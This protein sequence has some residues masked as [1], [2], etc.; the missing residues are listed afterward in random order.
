MLY[1]FYASLRRHV[2]RLRL[3]LLACALIF[4]LGIHQPR[5]AHAQN[6]P[7]RMPTVSAENLNE[8][9][10]V[11]PAQLP[12][13]KTLV[14]MAF[15]REQQTALNTWIDGMGLKDDKLPWIETP[16]I[17]KPF[18]LVRGFIDRGMRRGIPDPAM[19]ERTITLYT[20]PEE[21]RRVMGLSGDGKQVWVLVVDRS[22]LVLAQAT[23][24]YS[25]DKAKPLLDALSSSPSQTH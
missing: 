18:G 24:N 11:L 9:P 17:A 15:E 2:V 21:L 14:L 7:G 3:G 8:K 19:R 13:P 12:A 16:V 22:G 25:A 5:A 10:I 6:N 23:G 20:D 1:S 4:G